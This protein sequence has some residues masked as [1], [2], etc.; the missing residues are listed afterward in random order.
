MLELAN[1]LS[2]E[3]MTTVSGGTSVTFNINVKPVTVLKLYGPR[4]NMNVGVVVV[5]GN[6]APSAAS[7]IQGITT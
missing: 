2:H 3:D 6:L 1:E 5:A 4:L 7:L